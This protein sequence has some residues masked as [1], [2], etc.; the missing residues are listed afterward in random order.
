M[1]NQLTLF[2][3]QAGAPLTDGVEVALDPSELELDPAAMQARLAV[4]RFYLLRA[5]SCHLTV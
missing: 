5:R 2:C 1:T 3:Y 4:K